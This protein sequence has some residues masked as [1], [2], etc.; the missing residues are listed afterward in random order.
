MKDQKFR[1]LG[2]NLIVMIIFHLLAI[3]AL[4]Y[5]DT[6]LFIIALVIWITSHGLGLAL[7]FHR[8]L[9]HRGFQTSKLMEYI[10]TICGCLAMQ[11]GH[12]K[13]IA[14]HRKHHQFTD[15]LGDPHS[16]RDGFMYSHLWWMIDGDHS[17]ASPEFLKEYAPDLCKDRVHVFLNRF[18]YLPSMVLAIGLF[19]WGGMTAVLWGIFVPVAFGLEFTWMVNSVCHYWGTRRFKTNDDSRNNWFVA[20]LTWGEGWHNN[21]HNKPVRARHGLTWYEFDPA[22]WMIWLLS[23]VG[24]VKNIKL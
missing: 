12:I 17:L 15:K 7:G 20:I 13:W 22:W 23:K 16:P 1:F 6:S 5:Y 9:T 4:F 21:H 10:I 2:S 11:G 18:W 14:I 19:M 8:L 3:T 24:L